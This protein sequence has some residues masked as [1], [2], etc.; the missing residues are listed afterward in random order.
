MAKRREAAFRVLDELTTQHPGMEVTVS[1]DGWYRV[2]SP[3]TSVK[4]V[5]EG[6]WR[7]N[8]WV[9]RMFGSRPTLT[10]WKVPHG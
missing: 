2:K 1:Y 6:T 4:G 10:G 3:D 7:S 5:I 9:S 8:S